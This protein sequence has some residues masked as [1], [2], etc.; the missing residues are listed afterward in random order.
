MKRPLVKLYII[1][2]AALIATIT[3][4][5]T[6]VAKTST[7][8]VSTVTQADL[9]LYNSRLSD[10]DTAAKEG[11]A[12][13]VIM[14]DDGWATQFTRGYEILSGY[15]MKACIAVV[16]SLVDTLGYM[17]YIQLAELYMD[18]W[19]LLNHTNNH[20]D[21]EKLSRA[22]QEQQI[23]DARTWLLNHQFYRGA[24]IVAYPY[25]AFSEVTVSVLQENDFAVGRSQNSVWDAGIGCTREDIE[26]C[27][28]TSDISFDDAKAA[29]DKAISTGSAVI[30][31]LH[32]IEPVT[33]DT[34]M[35]IDEQMFCRIVEY[36]DHNKERISVVT[37]TQLLA[38]D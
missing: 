34:Q 9:L 13:V 26:V 36:I 30:I 24:D 38:I 20:Y 23:V 28:L 35:Q 25:G 10:D 15:D 21:L 1:I 4:L 18:G 19:D 6:I 37:M 8:A 33:D 31:I 16:P 11:I 5:P 12:H 2:V 7:W 14:M 22:E 29:I 32:K 27:N 3:L 17:T